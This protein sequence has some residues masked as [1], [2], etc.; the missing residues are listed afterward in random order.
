MPDQFTTMLTDIAKAAEEAGPMRAS[1]LI[2]RRG[3][4][5]RARQRAAVGVVAAVAVGAIAATGFTLGLHRTATNLP[6]IPP[7][8]TAT[9]PPTATAAPSETPT[10][11]PSST[12]SSQ[13]N[14]GSVTSPVPGRC[15][16]SN[17]RGSFHPFEWPGQ[18]GAQ[19]EADLGL[20][21]ISDQTCVIF[22][23]PGV[24][25]V[26][27]DGKSRATN[28]VRTTNRPS[29]SVTLTPGATAWTLVVWTFTPSADEANTNPLCGG[30]VNEIKVIPPDETSQLTVKADV[31]TVCSHGDLTV[32]P[33]QVNRPSDGPPPSGS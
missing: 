10:P 4:Q 21:N 12:G 5:R 16:A 20:T 32:W 29:R 17:L 27:P 23:F 22:G 18:A 13:A 25:L 19:A 7:N 8:P 31:G 1:S 6:A 3:D 14:A 15:H 33:F 2:R 11:A 26:G 30:H 28:V 24:Q 9:A